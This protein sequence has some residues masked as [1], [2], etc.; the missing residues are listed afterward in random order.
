MQY[1]YIL[2]TVLA[3]LSLA[4]SAHKQDASG[5]CS[6]GRIKSGAAGK[7][8]IAT[9]EENYYDVQHVKFNISLSNTSTYV[10]GDVTTTAKVVVPSMTVYAF[11]LNPLLTID[12]FKLNNTI[13]PVTTSGSVRTV[14]ISSLPL[15]TVF[16]AQVFYKGSCAA[17]NGQFFTGG[18]HPVS[19]GGFN[20]MYSISD[21]LFADDWWPCKQSLVDK[22]D[23]VD[24]WVTVDDTLKVGS[25]GLLK[26]TTTLPANKRRYEWKTIYPIDYY[27]ISV[28]VAPYNEYSYYMHFTDGSND[29]M[30]IQ[31]Y[32]YN[33][34]GHFT[35]TA[36]TALDSTG[37]IVDYFS[38]LFGRYPFDK[39]KYGHSMSALSGG[40]E[41]QTMTT[42]GTGGYNDVTLIA[43]ELGHQWWGNHVTYGSWRDIWLSEGITTYCEQL[44]VEKFRG[45]AA[46]KAYRTGV[47]NNAKAASGSVYVD[48]TTDVN[49]IFNGQLTYKKGAAV[50]HMLRYL[51]PHDSLFFKG[52]RAYQ[53][54]YKMS[55]AFTADL[56]QH[57]QTAYGISLDTF[58][59][60]WIYKEGFPTYSAKWFWQ[61]NQFVIQLKQTTTKPTSVP[62]FKMPVEIKLTT[63]AGD[64]I[65][66]LFNGANSET[67]VLGAND[68]VTAIQ[69]DPNDHIINNTGLI[70]KDASVLNIPEIVFQDVAVSPNPTQDAWLVSGLPRNT[71]CS[72]SDMNG[73]ILWTS[74]AGDSTIIQA[75]DMA[76][77]V[78]MLSLETGKGITKHIRVVK[79]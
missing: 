11:E 76:G 34:A 51:A 30:L 31:N 56:Q 47:M 74:K 22:I 53:Q 55:V 77:G 52:M 61:N 20:M 39:E 60:Q 42:L 7:T 9:P 66:K 71:K 16:T 12:S 29:S 25:N 49:R 19:S 28:A 57:M 43:H 2:A 37:L 73:K 64:R 13:M 78:Y 50:T 72:L 27:L 70:Q 6:A 46:F 5:I 15:N 33:T 45:D 69:I 54:Q 48:D 67:F 63:T 23:S 38:K 32:V 26:N 68:E 1:R 4:A 59:A 40:M 14:N 18:L 8:T 24:M 62:C 58:F 75:A 21:N 3:Y 17:G 41:H 44:F 10:S 35:P 79:Y 36:K 65:I